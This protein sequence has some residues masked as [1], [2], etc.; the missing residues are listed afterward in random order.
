APKEAAATCGAAGE[1]CCPFHQCSQGCCV[2]GTC[3]GQGAPCVGLGNPAAPPMCNNG[4][5]GGNC[6]GPNLA[7][8]MGMS[9]NTCTTP[10]TQCT[11]GNCVSCGMVGQACCP[12]ATCTPGNICNQAAGDAGS[13]CTQCGGPNETCCDVNSMVIGAPT[14]P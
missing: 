6:G 10:F 4:L 3:V 7:C 5:C 9:A 14:S 12:G 1:T 13:T 11:S 2:Y 8:C